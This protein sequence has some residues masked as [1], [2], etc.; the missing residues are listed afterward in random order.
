ME[1]YL[2]PNLSKA[3]GLLILL[4]DN[5]DG[6]SMVQIEKKLDLPKTT[7]FRILKTLCIS[8]MAC[9]MGNLYFPGSALIRIGLQVLHG[10]Q[11]RQK[12]LPILRELTAKTH[13]TSH[14]AIPSGGYSLILEVCDSPGPLRVASRPGTLVD[15]HCSSTGKVFLATLFYDKL[16]EFLVKYP[17]SSRTE[18][19]ITEKGKILSHLET[20]RRQGYAVDDQEYHLGVR[21]LACPVW[22][23]QDQVVAAIGITGPVS[24]LT[25]GN[26]PALAYLVMQ[27]ADQLSKS[28]GYS[29]KQG[30]E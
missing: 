24:E 6:V 21:C 1:Q 5:P 17:M 19:T 18:F 29:G 20:I 8:E 16:D 10:T 14:I 3:C 22:D 4:S 9:K 15:L 12:G 26:V 23:M 13:L 25:G 28:L 27:T 30:K 2:I 7:A 11:L